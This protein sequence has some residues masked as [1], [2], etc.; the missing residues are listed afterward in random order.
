MS[1]AAVCPAPDWFR[2]AIVG[3]LQMLFCLRLPGTPAQDSI[4]ATAQVWVQALWHCGTDWRERE[5]AP[6][7]HAAFLTL[8]HSSVQWCAPRH[9]LDAL[10]GHPRR[11]PVAI[12]APQPLPPGS[13][14]QMEYRRALAAARAHLTR[15]HLTRTPGSS[16]PGAS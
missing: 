6:R 8:C 13:A 4:T 14:R 7:L 15:A 16:G 3:G 10:G 2:H 12:A 1:R 9:L 11:A 5:D